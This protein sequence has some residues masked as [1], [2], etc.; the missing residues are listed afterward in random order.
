M[1]AIVTGG[2]GFLGLRLARALVERGTLKDGE[3]RDQPITELVMVDVTE[4]AAISDSRVQRVTGDISDPS[5]LKSIVDN[6]TGA[7]FHLAAI[8][9]GMAEADFD[10]GMRINVDATRT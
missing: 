1:K 3:G 5:L 7:I 6:N 2:A 8:V 9:S 4:P 10:L